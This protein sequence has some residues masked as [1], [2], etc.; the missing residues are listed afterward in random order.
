MLLHHWLALA[1][2][3]RKAKI[4]VV[5]IDELVTKQVVQHQPQ[6]DFNSMEHPVV[7]VGFDSIILQ[8]KGSIKDDGMPIGSNIRSHLTP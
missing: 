2:I 6:K 5:V 4:V 7:I 1:A 8:Q 3:I